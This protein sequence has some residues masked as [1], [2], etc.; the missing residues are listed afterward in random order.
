MDESGPTLPQRYNSD[1]GF[2]HTH[3]Y[4]LCSRLGVLDWMFICM[5]GRGDGEWFAA[6]MELYRL[7]PISIAPPI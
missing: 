3:Y 5:D 1:D 6:A 7:M 2:R 4:L